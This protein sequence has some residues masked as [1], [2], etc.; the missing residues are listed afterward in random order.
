MIETRTNVAESIEKMERHKTHAPR[1]ARL[2]D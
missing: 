2:M 1:N